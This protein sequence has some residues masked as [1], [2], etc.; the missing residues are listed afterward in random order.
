MTFRMILN[1]RGGAELEDK[2]YVVYIIGEFTVKP[3]GR[4]VRGEG[5]INEQGEMSG[6]DGVICS[7]LR[8]L[9]SPD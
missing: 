4:R 7:F 2:A 6:H 5:V 9:R 8:S 1:I 3:V